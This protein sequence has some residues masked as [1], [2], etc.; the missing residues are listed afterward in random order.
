MCEV[1]VCARRARPRGRLLIASTLNS[2]SVAR[3]RVRVRVSTRAYLRVRGT[4]DAD[5]AATVG[6]AVGEGVDVRRLVL[7]RQ[8]ALIALTVAGDVLG[9]PRAQ[10]ADGLHDELSE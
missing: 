2:E 8:A 10:A 6:D 5:A 3:V 9:V 4:W 1:C 7:A